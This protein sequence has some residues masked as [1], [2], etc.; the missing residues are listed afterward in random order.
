M[1]NS[2]PFFATFSIPSLLS[3]DFSSA[4]ETISASLGLKVFVYFFEMG[5]ISSFLA[6]LPE[7]KKWSKI[8][9][10]KYPIFENRTKM[11]EFIKILI[12]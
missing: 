6:A 10:E 1:Y 8:H 12:F 5:V 9:T 2:R 7:I 3:L 4:T 11:Y